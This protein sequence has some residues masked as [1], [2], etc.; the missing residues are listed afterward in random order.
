LLITN[1]FDWNIHIQDEADAPSPP[2]QPQIQINKNIKQEHGIE[3]V[4]V[5]LRAH[6]YS[7]SAVSTVI[8]SKPEL[9]LQ[10]PEFQSL[11]P[12]LVMPPTPTPT[13]TGVDAATTCKWQV[14][15]V[16]WAKVTGH[17][18]W[19]CMVAYDPV[20]PIFTK[21]KQGNCHGNNIFVTK[22]VD[23]LVISNLVK[24]SSRVKFNISKVAFQFFF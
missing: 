14:G 13:E 5:P 8:E 3:T 24:T 20:L 11:D 22:L 17:P 21:V 7:A 4:E 19:P 6:N 9:T 23:A 2:A 18:W 16:L 15:D 10:L 12:L 1:L